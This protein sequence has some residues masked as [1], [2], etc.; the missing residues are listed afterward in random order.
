[1]KRPI[2]AFVVGLWLSGCRIDVPDGVLPCERAGDC[3]VHWV[4][5]GGHCVR[6]WIRASDAGAPQAGETEV[7]S[8]ARD[9]S[10]AYDARSAPDASPVTGTSAPTRTPPASSA[11]LAAQL[12]GLD[13]GGAYQATPDAALDAA[14]ADRS[15][16]EPESC[17]N[18]GVDA[19]CD[20]TVDEGLA[21]G[22]A[23]IVAGVAGVCATGVFQCVSA[24]PDDVTCVG[25]A[26]T[27][28]VCNAQDDD[29]D[30]VVDEMFALASDASHCGAC[31]ARCSDDEVCCGG[32]CQAALPR[33]YGAA[34]GGE[35]SEPGSIQCDGSC[36]RPDPEDLGQACGQCGGRIQCDGSCSVPEPPDYG[37]RCSDGISTVGCSGSCECSRVCPDGERV[38]CALPCPIV[39][40]TGICISF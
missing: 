19:D 15:A 20:G 11:D 22:Q 8:A 26:P 14:E 6:P 29:C 27:A 39:C 28:E 5:Q 34:C 21:L 25:A 23:C 36:D 3:P 33:D 13:G 16:C 40:R 9:A 17:A 32:L 2:G 7:L 24:N 30:G 38:A 31:G 10:N 4:C 35:C 12:L 37:A 1:M 18:Q